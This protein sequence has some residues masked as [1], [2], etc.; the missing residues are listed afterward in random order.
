[1]SDGVKPTATGTA[2][3]SGLVVGGVPATIDATGIH[4]N[5]QG[6]PG[7]DPNT[8]IATVLA[9][10]GIHLALTPGT[11]KTTGGTAEAA[12][13]ALLIT[14]PTP[15]AGPVPAGFVTI[16]LGSTH[17]QTAASP[18]AEV[19]ADITDV[20]AP[21]GEVLGSS[22]ASTGDS[23]GGTLPD[24]SAG[25]GTS[26]STGLTPGAAGTPGTGLALNTAASQPTDYHFGGVSGRLVLVI[27][28]VGIV[29]VRL[30]RRY[31]RRLLSIG[32]Q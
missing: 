4:A 21:L 13:P 23:G 18:G 9:A 3:V 12:A 26:T 28:L 14:M 32:S 5:G 16:V 25:G 22:L 27:L 8:Q 7:L 10:S 15:G 11:V 24:L 31:M 6:T 29:G 2:V 30:I 17:A 1:V 19:S 20:G